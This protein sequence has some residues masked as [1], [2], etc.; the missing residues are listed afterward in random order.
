MSAVP[1]PGQLIDGLPADVVN[2]VRGAVVAVLERHAARLTAVA[3]PGDG[4]G[5]A[6]RLPTVEA[7][8]EL[9]DYLSSVD[10]RVVCL[11]VRFMSS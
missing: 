1:A 4:S 5:G 6:E 2:E 8:S 11:A 7:L 3:A 9:S 10:D